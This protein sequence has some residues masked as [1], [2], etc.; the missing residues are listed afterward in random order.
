MKTNHYFTTSLRWTTRW[1]QWRPSQ[2]QHSNSDMLFGNHFRLIDMRSWSIDRS[3]DLVFL[4]LTAI[5]SFSMVCYK[6]KSAWRANHFTHARDKLRFYT[7]HHARDFMYQ[8]PPLFLVKRW[9]DR[10]AWGQG[11]KSII[12]MHVKIVCMIVICMIIILL[13][14]CACTCMCYVYVHRT[15]HWNTWT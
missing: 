13:C 12:I 11:Y 4:W 9:K 5:V 2:Q 1:F 10:G 7:I 8:A 3:I 14:V 15:H 6:W